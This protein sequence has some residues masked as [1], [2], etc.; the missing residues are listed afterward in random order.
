MRPFPSTANA[1]HTISIDGGRAPRWAPSGREL[2]YITDTHLV[3]AEVETE[4]AFVVGERRALFPVQGF[5]YTQVRSQ[6]DVTLDDQRFVM[7][8][9]FDETE[10][11]ELVI[12]QNFF[13]ELKERVPH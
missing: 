6:Y 1:K 11:S 2:F 10:S 8:R 7:I 12:V 9:N 5:R 3:S 13:E 4:N